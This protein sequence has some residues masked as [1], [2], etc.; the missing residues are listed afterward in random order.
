MSI[1][2][3]N[4]EAVKKRDDSRDDALVVQQPVADPFTGAIPPPPIVESQTDLPDPQVR[5]IEPPVVPLEAPMN[6]RPN[7]QSEPEPRQPS[8]PTMPPDE[9][10]Q[11]PTEFFEKKRDDMRRTD[12]PPPPRGRDFFLQQQEAMK[13]KGEEKQ[14]EQP[15]V[16]FVREL[17]QSNMQSIME[18]LASLEEKVD[19]VY[20]DFAE[21]LTGGEAAASADIPWSF[22]CTLGDG[23]ITVANGYRCVIDLD[24]E[25]VAEAVVAAPGDGVVYMTRVYPILDADR[26]IITPGYWV[27]PTFGAAP[28]NN[29]ERHTIRIASVEDGVLT[30][31]H[32]GNISVTDWGDC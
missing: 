24:W 27:G 9:R 8:K 20:D 3:E 28:P 14:P 1:F 4:K 25:L 6:V 15:F 17:N 23:S 19:A 13:P 21:D 12:E 2:E 31:E 18:K 11:T 10:K 29:K 16:D 32:L 7:R 5:P 22:K 26:N 30:H